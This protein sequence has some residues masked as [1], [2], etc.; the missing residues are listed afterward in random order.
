MLKLSI[1]E[2]VQ[3]IE[4]QE[5][6]E[7]TDTNEGFVLKIDDYVPYIC[8]AIHNGHQLRKE[9]Q[10]KIA[11]NSAERW[12]EE[13]PHTADFVASMPIVMQGCDSRYEYDL[14]RAPETAIY[15]E[16]WGKK[17]WE[18]PLNESEKT[19][20]RQKHRQFY[21]VLTALVAQLEKKFKACVVYDIHSYNYRRIAR[22]TPVFNVGTEKISAHFETFVQAWVKELKK[23]K[24]PH[25]TTVAAI[26]DVFYGRGYLLDYVSQQFKNTLVLATEVKK[27]YC[28][29]TSGEAF[30]QIIE[31]LAK[32]FKKA[33]VDHAVFFA[34]H[35][36][37]LKVLNKHHLLSS[38]LDESILRVDT[39]LYR[40]VKDFEILSY[41]NPI[42]IEHEKKLFFQHKCQQNP[43]FR[44]S[45]LTINPF[46]LKRK[47][48]RISVEN[49]MDIHIQKMYKEVIDSY[50]DKVDMLANL[51]NEKFLINCLRYFGSPSEEDIKNANFLIYSPDM[52]DEDDAEN[53]DTETAAGIFLQSAAAYGFKFKI[54]TSNK[55]T[56]KALVNNSR[57]ALILK[58]GA[59]F[60]RRN[61]EALV[62]HEIGV[63]MVTTINA[64]LQPIQL[65]NIGLPLNTLT[66]EGLAI[67]S[68]YF[69]GNLT[70]MRLKELGLRVIAAHLIVKGYDFKET[71]A[72]LTQE[73]KMPAEKAFYL[74]TR[75]Y[76]G[77]GFTKDYLYLRGFRDILK[78]YRAGKSLNLLLIGKTSL[79][80]ADIIQ[81]MIERGMLKPPKYL[82][83]CLQNPQTD[84]SILNYLVNG[85]K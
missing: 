18:V 33:I 66:Q 44:Y 63:H 15:D 16:A 65:F 38:D 64:R 52:S 68:E 59:M 46:E 73:Y 23:I 47:L 43:Q 67:L 27:V 40:L 3:K 76:R 17:V 69:S 5:T 60:S 85:L 75:I 14:N 28:D 71:F 45:H 58:K 11:L 26:N 72:A 54:E 39:A 70:T 13:D 79:A 80:Y 78:Y 7:A 62:H 35:Q 20:S 57:Q 48:Y 12:Y 61:L 24:I 83:L 8:C 4:A 10:A 19:E 41:V 31:A 74:T 55:L 32:G 34:K 84:N 21:E 50:A 42:N 81:E 77:G 82:S 51:G 29:E 1:A 2:I 6:F 25:T 37:N 53:I 49:I 9:L 22:E 30:P 56:S 36:T